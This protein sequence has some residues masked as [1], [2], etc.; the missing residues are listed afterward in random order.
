VVFLRFLRPESAIAESAAELVRS[1]SPQTVARL[2]R[3]FPHVLHAFGL[4]LHLLQY[5]FLDLSDIYYYG[6]YH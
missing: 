2:A 6:L 4:A 3:D 1:L 5:N